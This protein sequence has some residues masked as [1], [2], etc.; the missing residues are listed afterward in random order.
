[1]HITD[2]HVSE[3]FDHFHT[4]ATLH[5]TKPPAEQLAAIK[6]YGEYLG[7]SDVAIQALIQRTTDFVPKELERAKGWIVMGFFLGLTSAERSSESK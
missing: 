7:M 1:M 6:A 2:E 3:A 4:V 5:F